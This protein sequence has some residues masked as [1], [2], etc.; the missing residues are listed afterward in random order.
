M[1]GDLLVA[2][3]TFNSEGMSSTREVAFKLLD[4]SAVEGYGEVDVENNNV[5]FKDINN[6]QFNDAF[7]LI[8]ITCP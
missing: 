8:Q 4:G 5:R 7:R 1:Q 3:Y 6:L 2:N